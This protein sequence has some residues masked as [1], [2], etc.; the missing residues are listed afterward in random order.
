MPGRATT[1]S[2]ASA[3]S[4]A[5]STRL[6]SDQRRQLVRRYDCL[7]KEPVEIDHVSHDPLR[8]PVQ[9]QLH[10]RR[11]A[12]R[13][14]VAT[15]EA[16]SRRSILWRFDFAAYNAASAKLQRSSTFV[17]F[18]VAMA[19]PTLT[20]TSIKRPLSDMGCAMASITRRAAFQA[21]SEPP[22]RPSTIMNSS[23]PTRA[24]KSLLRT[25]L[26]R[27]LGHDPEKLIASSMPETIVHLLE[28]IEVASQQGELLN[29]GDCPRQPLIKGDACG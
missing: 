15:D 7:P 14:Q 5:S 28:A 22:T 19:T 25:A 26:S 20:P 3:S 17:P 16:C 11:R 9:S 29:Q 13:T 8:T 4:K 10:L 27:A 18:S 24:T 12:V 1:H 21:P 2:S 23:P 6:L